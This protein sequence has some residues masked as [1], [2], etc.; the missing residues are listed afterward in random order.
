MSIETIR[1]AMQR[2]TYFINSAESGMAKQLVAADAAFFVPGQP[3]PLRGPEGYTQI[4]AMMRGGFS[5]I[6][7]TLEETIVEGE[8]VAARFTMRGTH[9]GIFFGVPA[10]GKGIE[11]TAMNFSEGKIVEEFGQ[12]DLLSLL[13]QIGA[14]PGN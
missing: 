7:W 1:V 11:V 3:E 14:I 5:D 6:Q 4:L 8:R 10:T 2:F 9:D 13:R 12:P